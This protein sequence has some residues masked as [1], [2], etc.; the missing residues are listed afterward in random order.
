MERMRRLVLFNFKIKGFLVQSF[1]KSEKMTEKITIIYFIIFFWTIGT[2]IYSLWLARRN[3]ETYN[4]KIIKL[5]EDIKD[6]K[7][8]K[9]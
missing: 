7:K 1:R 8:Q 9:D 2:T 3:N 5:L 4:K 6:G